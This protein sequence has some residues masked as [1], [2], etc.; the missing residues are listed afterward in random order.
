MNTLTE[1]RKVGK[2]ENKVAIKDAQDAQTAITQAIAVLEDF[3]KG[4]TLLQRGVDLP[5]KP[6]AWDSSAT[7]VSDPKAQPD[8]I[9][10][11]LEEVSADFAKMEADTKAQ[12]ESDAAAYKAELEET[13]LERKKRE[14]EVEMKT[15]KRQQFVDEIKSMQK[16]K[17]AAELELYNLEV[18]MKDLEPACVKS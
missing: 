3:Y 14:K 16:K 10:T 11:V 8:G 1:I 2:E 18:Y 13:D 9:I 4:V 12:E 6:E 7:A 17:K 15:Q 5:E